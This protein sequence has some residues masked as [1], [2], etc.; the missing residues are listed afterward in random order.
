M[1]VFCDKC[2]A[3][4]RER[5]PADDWNQYVCSENPRHSRWVQS[6]PVAYAILL[7]EKGLTYLIRRGIPPA[8]GGLCFPGG[9][10]DFGETP[11]ETVNHEV[12]DEAGID[13]EA[14]KKLYIGSWFEVA[15]VTVTCFLVRIRKH[16]VGEFVPSH[17]STERVAV[18]FRNLDPEI[19]AFTANR[20][21]LQAARDYLQKI[22]WWGDEPSI[23]R[24]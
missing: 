11:E 15:G 4:I 21:A 18:D 17:E 3:P 19:L 7:D 8:V 10:V 13:I 22:G 23:P 16:S 24:P 20:L 12:Q 6:P 9:Y 5:L 14:L 1:P 2:S